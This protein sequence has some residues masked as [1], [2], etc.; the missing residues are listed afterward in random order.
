MLAIKHFLLSFKIIFSG[1]TNEAAEVL[2]MQCNPN[3]LLKKNEL[4][5]HSPLNNYMQ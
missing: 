1:C 4:I 2:I 3:S 5:L